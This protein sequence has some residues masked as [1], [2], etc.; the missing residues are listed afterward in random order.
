MNFANKILHLCVY[1]KPN[2]PDVKIYTC[3]L[4]TRTVEAGGFQVK[5]QPKMFSKTLSY[6]RKKQ[7]LVLKP[8]GTALAYILRALLSIPRT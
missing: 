3:N 1:R 8:S 5:V 2:N 6:L 7:K 4:S